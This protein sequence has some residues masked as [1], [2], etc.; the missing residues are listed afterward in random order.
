M[1]LKPILSK[2]AFILI[3]LLATS[4]YH[5]KQNHTTKN[6]KEIVLSL[7]NPKK[8]PGGLPFGRGADYYIYNFIDFYCRCQGGLGVS[9]DVVGGLHCL[10][11]YGK[12]LALTH[13]E[14]QACLSSLLPLSSVSN[15]KLRPSVSG[16]SS[17]M[18]F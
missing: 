5:E 1:Y 18:K 13:K 7:Q 6:K 2:F 8:L 4:L 14:K 15:P 9:I 11:Y 16:L 10:F 17:T 3:I 12:M